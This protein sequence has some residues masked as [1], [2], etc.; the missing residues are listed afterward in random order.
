MEPLCHVQ[1]YNFLSLSSN[2]LTQSSSIG[3]CPLFTSCYLPEDGSTAGFRNVVFSV[4]ISVT[5]WTKCKKRTL[6]PRHL[7]THVLAPSTPL[8]LISSVLSTSI[9]T[10]SD[11]LQVLPASVGECFALIQKNHLRSSS[12]AL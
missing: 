4:Y 12:S 11:V 3:F 2:I 1:H 5:R 7:L 10:T 8:R 6:Q 9:F